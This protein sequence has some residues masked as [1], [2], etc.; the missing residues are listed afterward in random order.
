MP[1]S[2]PTFSSSTTNPAFVSRCASVA[3]GKAAAI[4]RGEDLKRVGGLTDIRVDVRV[5]AATNRNLAAEVKAGKFR[6]DLFYRLQV[7]PIELPPLRERHG[8]APLLASYFVDAYNREFKKRIRGSTPASIKL[9][10][11]LI[12]T[13]AGNSRPVLTGATNREVVLPQETR[14]ADYRS[15]TGDRPCPL[16]FPYSSSRTRE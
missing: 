13:F 2:P 16:T 10:D 12:S 3:A 8:D 6:E 5:V 7:M 4:S 9:I 14:N 15:R 11:Q 1:C